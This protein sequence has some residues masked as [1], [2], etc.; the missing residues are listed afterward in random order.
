MICI[1]GM[2]IPMRESILQTRCMAM[3]CIDLS[4]VI[5]MKVH[6]MK[7][8][9]KDWECIRSGMEKSKLGIGMLE[10]F[11]PPALKVMNLR[12]PW[13]L[14]TPKFYMLCRYIWPGFLTRTLVTM[15]LIAAVF[16]S[17]H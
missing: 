2:V 12:Q 6:G 10:Y 16:I 7:G 13:P 17:L 8:K 1:A 9:G 14:T 5:D 3:V 11:K 4:T 15:N